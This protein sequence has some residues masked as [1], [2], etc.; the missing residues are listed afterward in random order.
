MFQKSSAPCA[1]SRLKIEHSCVTR[2]TAFADL[3]R[4]AFRDRFHGMI[5]KYSA[6]LTL[7]SHVFNV[8]DF[9][10]TFPP[11]ERADA[12][13][14]LMLGIIAFTHIASPAD[15]LGSDY[16]FFMWKFCIAD[17][18]SVIVG[19]VVVKF[20]VVRTLSN[21]AADAAYIRIA[22]IIRMRGMFSSAFFAD[23]A[24]VIR[25][26]VLMSSC[27]QCYFI[28][29]H[30]YLG[31]VLF[32]TIMAMTCLSMGFGFFESKTESRLNDL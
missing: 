22:G 19:G 3:T 9:V 27:H 10:W 26:A 28:R 14:E 2:I 23:S 15:F 13:E 29:L 7:M 5:Q 17:V 21:G 6:F 8:Y 12:V 30:D 11:A 4:G 16:C 25:P 31:V 18:T 20:T 24:S 1:A 32:F